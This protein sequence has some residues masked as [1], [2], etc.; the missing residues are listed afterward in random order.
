MRAG[1]VIVGL[2]LAVR[3]GWAQVRIDERVEVAR[4]LVDA[5]VVDVRGR[6]CRGL[7]A[8]DFR[9]EIDGRPARLQSATWIGSAA[10]PDAARQNGRTTPVRAHAGRLIVFFVQWSA[11]P[12]RMGGILQM[13]RQS[14]QFVDRLGPDD[15]AGVVLFDSRLRLRQDF[16]SDHARL[17]SALYGGLL[18]EPPAAAENAAA[19][20]AAHLDAAKARKAA[21]VETAL[22]VLAEALAP[23]EGS[24]D[25]VLMG[26]GFGQYRPLPGSIVGTADLDRDYE[27]AREA[28]VRARA[29]VFA[30][31]I[32]DADEHSLAAGLVTAAEDT[33]GFYQKAHEFQDL[34]MARLEGALEGY[35]LLAVE[36]PART[37]RRH[38][39]KVDV[40]RKGTTVWARRYYVD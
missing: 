16:T 15:R 30:L 11:E 37:Q 29:T 6:P 1:L 2:L 14:A 3:P 25:L 17:R 26:H 20:I 19:R 38:T 33:G 35:Y 5:R 28:L 9:V 7:E 39:I 22:R 24:K 40:E 21:S 27:A 4:V 13:L 32:T 8:A 31:D 34:A 23:I 10:S 18:A 12:T 36:R